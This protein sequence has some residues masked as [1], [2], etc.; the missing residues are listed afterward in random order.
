[1]Y[2]ALLDKIFQAYPMY[3]KIGSAAYKEGLENIEALMDILDHPERKF[4]AVHIAG[5]NGK[6]SVAHLLASYFQ[7][8]GCKTGLFTSPHLVDFRE[9]IRL[10]GQMINEEA[11]LAF[12]NRYQQ[13]FDQLEPSFFEMTTALA[14]YYFAEQKVDVAVI[15][16]GLGGR[17]DAT[18]V[19]SPLLSI[20]TNISLEHTQML[21]DSI[22]K[23]SA[24]KAGIIKPKTPVVIGEFNPESFPVFED[25]ANQKDAPLFLAEDNYSFNGDFD[26]LNVIDV[27]GNT[28]YE[29]IQMPLHG[30]YQLKNLKTFLQATEVIEELWPAEKDVVPQAIRN[31]VSNTGFQGRWQILRREPLTIC[32]VGHNPGGLALTMKQLAQYPCRQLR[33]VFGMVSDKDI[34]KAVSLL[35]KNALY[36]VCQAQIE[37]ALPASE[38]VER[39]RQHGLQC[40]IAG[41]VADAFRQANADAAPDDLLFVGG[42]CFVVGELLAVEN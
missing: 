39:M 19:L 34:D 35:P 40:R 18:N 22:A 9:R 14:F 6:G 4:K 26:D 21:G 5:T 30:E 23:I 8:R 20:I 11:V 17:L 41:T 27:L 2:K 28:L 12:F 13:Q 15:E 33:M 1:M 36:Y 29:H 42:S 10:N 3:H 25:L 24:E 7:E 32:D 16:V 37:R 31:M 38:L